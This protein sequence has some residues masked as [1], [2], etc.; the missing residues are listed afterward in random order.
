MRRK[1]RPSRAHS[2]TILKEMRRAAGA[3][4]LALIERGRGNPLTR[5]VFWFLVAR[6]SGLSQSQIAASYGAWSRSGVG[7]GI[8]RVRSRLLAGCAATQILVTRTEARYLPRQ[9]SLP[10]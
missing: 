9:L 7:Y 8:R 5:H 4:G 6:D 1:T 2:L 3:P 10:F